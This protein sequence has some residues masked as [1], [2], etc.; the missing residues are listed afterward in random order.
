MNTA[1]ADREGGCWVLF[2][3]AEG[4]KHQ[5]CHGNLDRVSRYAARYG[6]RLVV[7]G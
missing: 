6:Y 7:I 4:R 5:L 2:T 3:Y 1:Y